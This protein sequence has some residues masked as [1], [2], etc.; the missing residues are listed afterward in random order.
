M[1]KLYSMDSIGCYS[2][3]SLVVNKKNKLTVT[4]FEDVG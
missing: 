4:E 3:E 1:K 2:F